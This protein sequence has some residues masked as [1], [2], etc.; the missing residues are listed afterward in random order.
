MTA[1]LLVSHERVGQAL[2]AAV[3]SIMQTQDLEL[4]PV[5]E[6]LEDDR[7]QPDRFLHRIQSEIQRLLLDDQLLILTDLPGATPHNLALRAVAGRGVP[8]VSGVN[9]AMLLRCV[10]HARLPAEELAEKAVEGAR[11]AIF[12]SETKDG[13]DVA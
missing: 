9:L 10:N 12:Q 8:V 13:Q 3:E 2:H 4:K 6:V 1:I 7:Q 5:V 11:S